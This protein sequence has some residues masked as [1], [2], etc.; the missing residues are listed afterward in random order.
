MSGAS[1]KGFFGRAVAARD[2]R[3]VGSVRAGMREHAKG[4]GA[5]LLPSPGSASVAHPLG[6]LWGRRELPRSPKRVI[7]RAAIAV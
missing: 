7:V 2:T 1:A 3:D 4:C 5:S 6:L